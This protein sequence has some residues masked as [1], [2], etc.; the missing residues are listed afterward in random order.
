MSDFA[1]P[2]PHIREEKLKRMSEKYCSEQVSFAA[3]GMAVT[4]FV[5]KF[6]VCL[7]VHFGAFGLSQGRFSVLST[8]STFPDKVWTPASLAQ[9]MG[10]RRPTMTG[11]LD[12]LE[13]DGFIV[14]KPHP[15]DRRQN[16]IVLT[17]HGKAK[18][19]CVVAVHFE[20]VKDAMSEL[21]CDER[22]QF[23]EL[24]GKLS[25]AVQKMTEVEDVS[26]VLTLPVARAAS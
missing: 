19:D 16:I 26:E 6:N 4:D 25:G 7:D 5:S 18:F 8:L 12:G 20:R 17:E 11:F 21:S 13:R 23:M 2:C 14:R 22:E 9:A 24:L 10:V 3:L 15:D 1:V